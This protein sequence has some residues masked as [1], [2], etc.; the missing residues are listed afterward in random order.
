MV[1]GGS[2]LSSLGLACRFRFLPQALL[3]LLCRSMSYCRTNCCPPST[4]SAQQ[5]EAVQGQDAVGSVL[6][7]LPLPA[8][9]DGVQTA[10]ALGAL[11]S[12]QQLSRCSAGQ[13]AALAGLDMGRCAACASGECWPHRKQVYCS[14]TAAV[15]LST[16]PALQ[17]LPLSHPWIPLCRCRCR[18][19]M[20]IEAFFQGS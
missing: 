9:A 8:G 1:G 4:L 20:A 6:A 10:A 15:A 16:L 12:L 17:L 7:G 13:L 14:A 11:G 18:S 3:C 5:A 19:A 2:P